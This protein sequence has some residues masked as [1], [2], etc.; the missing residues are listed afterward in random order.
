MMDP[1]SMPILPVTRPTD[2]VERT[3]RPKSS[4]SESTG[5]R[6]LRREPR[7]PRERHDVRDAREPGRRG[8]RLAP[9]VMSSPLS[10]ESPVESVNSL[11]VDRVLGRLPAGDDRVLV[12]E[13]RALA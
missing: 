1:I 5:S 7:E 12:G 9:K 8:G 11:P 6:A 3:E 10:D 2:D 13:A 4:S